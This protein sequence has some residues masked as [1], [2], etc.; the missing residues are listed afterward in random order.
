MMMTLKRAS[1]MCMA[2]WREMRAGLEVM[3]TRQQERRRSE[4][5]RLEGPLC[6][7][8]EQCV[9]PCVMRDVT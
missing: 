8:C 6:P 3:L 1:V 2:R 5:G 7:V 4:E 9:E